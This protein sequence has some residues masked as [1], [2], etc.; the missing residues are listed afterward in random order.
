MAEARDL[1]TA[2]IK[3]NMG[4]QH[5][6]THGVFRMVVTIDGEKITSCVPYIGYLHRGSEK[7]AEGEQFHQIVTLFDR[8]D[9]LSNFN[10]E[11][12]YCMAVEKVMGL[13]IPP[14]A[15]YVR[16]LL[17]ELQRICSH[18]LLL[19]SFGLDTGAI[20]PSLYAFRI[21]ERIQ[22]LFEAVTGARM[23]HNY[24]HIGGLKEDLPDDFDK[25]M[26]ELMSVLKF[27]IEEC[28]KLLSFN[29]IFLTRTKGLAP[30]DTA[31]AI[32]LGITGP[33]LRSTGLKYDVRKAAPYSS[34]EKFD[35]DIPTGTTGDCWD[36]YWMRVQEMYQ[37]L[38]I[39]EQ[40]W[41]NMPDGPVNVVG[42]RLLRPPKGEAYV[43][44]E[45]PRGEIGVYLVTDGTDK[46]YRLKVR[47]PS[48]C[49]LMAI[50]EMLKDQYVADAVVILGSLDIVLG[51]VD[52]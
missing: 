4:P 21:R 17:S 6:S 39:I 46:P 31:T 13:E 23:M 9:Y 25:R 33:V 11:L 20:T 8:M 12:V 50:S 43:R 15:Q 16:V 36:R 40:A 2:E 52:R 7:V 24:C 14:R 5:P 38:K 22:A 37:A 35:F 3:V 29:E 44:A 30:M 47:P 42:R 1:Q 49:N 28:D 32:E 45:N 10:N 19:G 34:Y 41:K 48:Y 18:I 51:E 27:D 26:S